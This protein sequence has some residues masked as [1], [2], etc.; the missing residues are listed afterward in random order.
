MNHIRVW[1]LKKL[2]I[3]ETSDREGNEKRTRLFCRPATESAGFEGE[4]A[5]NHIAFGSTHGR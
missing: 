3:G 4:G 5:E 2:W 1:H